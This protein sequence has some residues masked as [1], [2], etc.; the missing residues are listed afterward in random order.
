MSGNL[1]WRFKDKS[2]EEDAS[3]LDG[4]EVYI[5]SNLGKV[6]AFDVD[7]TRI[8]NASQEP[9]EITIPIENRLHFG[10]RYQ[11][12][13]GFKQRP[14]NLAPLHCRLEKLTK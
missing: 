8:G 12:I 9:V 13:V 6:M 3:I 4:F 5:R 14:I 10:E 1:R 11:F 2:T 7:L